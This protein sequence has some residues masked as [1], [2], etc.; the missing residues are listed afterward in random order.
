M[1][2]TLPAENADWLNSFARGMAAL[3]GQ[4]E[5]VLAGGD[6]T[7]GPL[8]ISITAVGLVEKG[9]ALL[10][11]GASAGDLVVVSGRPG[12]AANALKKLKSG[13]IPDARDLAA[14]EYPEPRLILGRSLRGL[15]TS[16]IDISDGLIAD[17]GHILEQSRVGAEIDLNRLPCPASL[18][19]IPGDERWPLQLA[20]G[21]D[22][23]LCFTIPSDSEQEL[24]RLSGACG[25]PLSVIG[26]VTGREGMVLRRSDGGVYDPGRRGFL[27]FANNGE[28][29]I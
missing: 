23:E 13:E 18:E 3:A 8:S 7:S 27:H 1:A 20:G 25:V 26:T 2:L 28:E 14:L 4:S 22:Y 29:P 21:D 10:R 24:A 15:A 5:V 17:L 11:S 12:A 6:V 9:G 16:C 19:N